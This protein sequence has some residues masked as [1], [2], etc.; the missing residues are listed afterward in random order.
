MKEYLEAVDTKLG[1][2]DEI[3]D[4]RVREQYEVRLAPLVQSYTTAR[5]EEANRKALGIE[6]SVGKVTRLV[7]LSAI[8]ALLVAVLIALYL[9]HSIS[10]PLKKLTAAA[11][12][13]GK[14]RLGSRIQ[15]KSWE[16][17]VP[18][19]YFHHLQNRSGKINVHA[20]HAMHAVP[21][22]RIA[23]GRLGDSV[24]LNSLERYVH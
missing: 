16:G 13:M 19:L 24:S 11:R 7:A 3:L 4:I 23:G 12:E 22:S 18:L 1:E 15:I 5:Y 2:A 9:S 14:G 8:G 10:Q 17:K 21:G 20:P 6:Q